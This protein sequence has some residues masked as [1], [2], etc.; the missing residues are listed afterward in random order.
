MNEI[1]PFFTF[2]LLE[3]F[4]F[5]SNQTPILIYL[6]TSMAWLCCTN[7]FIIIFGSLNPNLKYQLRLTPPLA[8]YKHLIYRGYLLA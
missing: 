5:K 8:L 1:K 4:N 2:K 3:I 7:P 6:T